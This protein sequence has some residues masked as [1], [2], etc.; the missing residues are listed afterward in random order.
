MW[1]DMLIGMFGAIEFASTNV[2]DTAFQFDQTWVRGI[3]SCDVALRHEAAFGVLD[4][5]DITL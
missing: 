1:S 5:L 4:N 3:L 2:G